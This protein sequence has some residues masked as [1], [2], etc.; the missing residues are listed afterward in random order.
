MRGEEVFRGGDDE[1]GSNRPASGATLFITEILYKYRLMASPR[2]MIYNTISLA[3]LIGYPLNRL[4]NLT[5]ITKLKHR[6]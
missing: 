1:I 6:T 5:I 3:N 4:I 2:G